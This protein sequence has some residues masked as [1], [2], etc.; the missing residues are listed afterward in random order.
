MNDN[1]V[2]TIEKKA[3]N[4]VGLFLLLL[5]VVAAIGFAAYY[6][7]NNKNLIVFEY[8]FPWEKDK[9][10]DTKT[11]KEQKDGEDDESIS[12]GENSTI[13][14]SAD[15]EYSNDD[16]V[17]RA[18]AANKKEDKYVVSIDFS[19][20]SELDRIIDVKEV[21]ING[22]QFGISF[23]VQIGPNSISNYELGIPFET[24]GKYGIE[25]VDSIVLISSDNGEDKN[26]VLLMDADDGNSNSKTKEKI[27]NV[28]NKIDIFYYK[29][30]DKDNK[31]YVYILFN[32]KDSFKYTFYISR[33]YVNDKLIDSSSYTGLL[34]G[35][36]KYAVPIEVE[37]KV[38]SKD[39]K[40]KIS[41]L[42][43]RGDDSVYRTSVKKIVI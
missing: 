33:L 25:I 28:E 6:Y 23:R 9:K 38:F 1:K 40:I 29:K 35:S 42:F 22:C 24:L 16:L 3:T 2:V 37:K 11:K 5:V 10:K 17:V 43:I 7:I 12:S 27:F 19:N 8:K 32:N 4:K 15:E 31:I 18:V 34:Y 30:V 20:E 39:I 36:N 41:F 14:I 26:L 13:V 21:S